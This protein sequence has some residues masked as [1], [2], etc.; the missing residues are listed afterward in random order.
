MNDEPPAARGP[1]P[2]QRPV[3]LTVLERVSSRTGRDI[4][5]YERWDGERRLLVVAAV[6]PRTGREWDVRLPLIALPAL[7]RAIAR[8]QEMVHEDAVRPLARV[9]G[10]HGRPR[11]KVSP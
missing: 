4:I 1:S 10:T 8:L 11:G 6:D 2:A 5:F 7:Q 3:T 9:P